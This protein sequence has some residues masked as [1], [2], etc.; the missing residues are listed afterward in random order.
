LRFAPPG[1]DHDPCTC[2]RR[3]IAPSAD[4]VELPARILLAVLPHVPE[5]G[6]RIVVVPTPRHD[7]RRVFIPGNSLLRQRCALII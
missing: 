7:A 2:D 5:A 1:R 3:A 4:A 6:I